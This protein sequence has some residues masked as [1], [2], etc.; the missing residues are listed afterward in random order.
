MRKKHFWRN[1]TAVVV[2]T[3]MTLNTFLP[4]VYADTSPGK[5]STA[6][7][8]AD[9]SSDTELISEIKSISET[10]VVSETG[11][12]PE[13]EAVSETGS[14]SE[15][16]AASETAP[17]PGTELI[18]ETGS[19]PETELI[20]EAGS[21]PE[22]ESV[23]KSGFSSESEASLETEGSSETQGSS[24][25]QAGSEKN[26][27][28][29]KETDVE[30]E[31]VSAA[32]NASKDTDTS[33]STAADKAEYTGNDG[34]EGT[35]EDAEEAYNF[36]QY[37]MTEG[38]YLNICYADGG[39][40]VLTPADFSG[41]FDV[42][43]NMLCGEEISYTAFAS[44]GY[45][46]DEV[47][48]MSEDGTELAYYDGSGKDE[49]SFTASAH[50]DYKTVICVSFEKS[51]LPDMGQVIRF[52]GTGTGSI[53]IYSDEKRTDRIGILD[54]T[55]EELSVSEYGL[56]FYLD[57]VGE[58]ESASVPYDIRFFRDGEEVSSDTLYPMVDGAFHA[59]P[60]V[61]FFQRGY[62]VIEV[63]IKTMSEIGSIPELSGDN[64]YGK[65][66]KLV[67][68]GLQKDITKMWSDPETGDVYK[69]RALVRSHFS[70][71][72]YFVNQA[73]LKVALITTDSDSAEVADF[74]N[75]TVYSL[76]RCASTSSQYCPYYKQTGDLYFIITGVDEAT[77]TV[78]YEL[79]WHNDNGLS[80]QHAYKGYG[81]YELPSGSL[82]IVK[83]WKQPD[84]MEEIDLSIYSL[85]ATFTLY[86]DR[87]CT[88]KVL[89][90]TTDANGS[91]TVDDLDPGTYYIKE[92]T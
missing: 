34:T 57:V 62:E 80:Y 18:P 3:A 50:I 52:T 83:A 17:V 32:G 44:D 10:D 31:P 43:V 39:T 81:S 90:V 63:S 60:A 75:Q 33:D 78:S 87:D 61:S 41:D 25:A 89:S 47:S 85:K 84:T 66:D 5:S 27:G 8:T 16:E 1:L 42:E 74:L 72:N 71:T 77:G 67:A 40:Q 70:P 46:I 9:T 26:M 37:L 21:V 65:Y 45:V 49:L 58:E 19:V 12:V 7:S 82:K 92:T 23:S 54:E 38:G 4:V 53:S 79:Y 22:T 55:G 11:A 20:S 88:E 28:A 56:D 30:T 36:I 51:G 29:E 69:T 91:A 6:E 48:V 59:Y 13:V 15:T 73:P 86:S 35:T 2:A 76:Y 68:A 64:T 24:E 14:L